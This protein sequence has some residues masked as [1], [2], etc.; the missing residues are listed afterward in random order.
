MATAQLGEDFDVHGGGLDL[1]F[2]HH[3]NERAQSEA[4]GER[5]A[6][7]WMHNGMLRLDGEKMSKSLGNIE[8]LRRGARRV[9]RETLLSALR[10]GALPQPGRLL[11]RHA[12]AGAATAAGLRE[13]LR[14]ARRY[15]AGGRHRERRRAIRRGAT[16]AFEAL[17][18]ALADDLDTPR[19]LAELFGLARA[20]NSARGGG[21]RRPGRRRG[22]RRPARERARRA[23]AR[24]RST[25]RPRPPRRGARPGRRA[26]EP[27][28]PR[29]TT[30]APTSCATTSR[31]SASP[32]ATPRR[33]RRSCPSRLTAATSRRAT[34]S[35]TGCNPCARRCAA[36]GACARSSSRARRPRRCPGSRAPA[37]GCPSPSPTA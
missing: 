7:I 4:A 6:R 23:R 34:T 32:C 33:G 22:R 31:R 15:A 1:I 36:A 37:C 13:A 26:R 17:R 19:A 16:A 2:P 28:A 8:R 5:F 25:A 35:S 21:Q 29:A 18:R 24:R 11:R 30:R 14:N 27:R 12:R 9:G 10:A 3:E 20:V